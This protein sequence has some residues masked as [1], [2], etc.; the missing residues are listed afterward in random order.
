MHTDIMH[1]LV[2][3]T[4]DGAPAMTGIHNGF[5]ALSHKDEDFPDFINYHCIILQQVLVSK[6]INT[7]HLMDISFKIV[8]SIK[9]K[10]PPKAAL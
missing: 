7:K 9:G 6:R 1:K 3:M 4:T 2:S 8:N 10:S 5:I